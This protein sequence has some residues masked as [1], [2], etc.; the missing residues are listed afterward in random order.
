MYVHSHSAHAM[1]P[2][3]PTQALVSSGQMSSS[4]KVQ[5]LQSILDDIRNRTATLEANLGTCAW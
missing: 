3:Q 2:W 4:R 1:S 5:E